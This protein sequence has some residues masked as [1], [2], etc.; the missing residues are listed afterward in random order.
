MTLS[1]C[2]G[3]GKKDTLHLEQQ[4]EADKVEAAQN[5]ALALQISS[6]QLFIEQLVA[7]AQ[8][9]KPE[10]LALDQLYTLSQDFSLPLEN[11]GHAAYRYAEL[12]F[13]FENSNAFTVF[14]NTLSTWGDHTLT[15]K[16]H[17][18]LAEQWLLV[19]NNEAAIH[20][21]T[22]AFGQ[23]SMD[24]YT[25]ATIINDTQPI[26]GDVSESSAIQ[27]MLTVSMFDID[28]RELWLQQ[29]AKYSTLE[30]VLQLRQSDQPILP[31]QA[32]Y[33]RYVAR[34]RLMVGDYHA[35]RIIA[36][37]LDMDMPDSEAAVVVKTWAENEGELTVV[38]VLL[39]L[40]GKY[41]VYGQQALKGIRLAMSRPDFEDHIILRIQDTAGNTDTTIS[42]YQ[43]MASQGVQW[44]IGPLLSENTAALAPFL[45]E[46]IPVIA[47]SNQVQLA[48]TS[49]SLF[50]HS[51][52]KTVQAGFM[53]HYA[54]KQGIERVVIIHDDRHSANEEAAAFAQTFISD[55]GEIIDT[56]LLKDR[57]YDNRPDLVR[58]R[59]QTDDEELLASLDID[60]NLFSPEREFDIKMPLNMDAIYIATSGKKLSV[61]AGQMA[62]SDINNV[63]L[64]GSYRW[65]DGHLMDDDGRYLSRAKFATPITSLSQPDQAILDVHNQYRV[66]WAEG[67]NIAPLF[68]IAYDTAMNIAALGTRLGLEG[69]DAIQVLSTTTS[70]PAISGNYYFDAN[71]V[72]QKTFAVQTIRKGEIKTVRMNQ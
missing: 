25:L 10:T 65:F 50:I 47:L 3:G 59:S 34:E 8:Q 6:T 40:S 24:E 31:V 46:H 21:F 60:L 55:G 7:Q 61:L 11:Q 38:G 16:A 36:K 66:I 41:A 35:V 1:G 51:L 29:A 57:V 67:N 70:F 58:M 62:Y 30:Y 68:A 63:Q 17:V 37:I 9:E 71:G 26:L 14:E 33:Y 49:P 72:S 28:N 42:A 13:T 64:Y 45:F 56:L 48:S 32:D 15:P 18:F 5:Q 54:H 39:P 23:A 69:E 12:L 44:V 27:W 43:N 4:R 52:A 20:E 19:E 22:A 2:S 53:A